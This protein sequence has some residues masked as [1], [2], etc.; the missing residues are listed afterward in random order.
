MTP[1]VRISPAALGVILV[2]LVIQVYLFETV[3]GAVLDGQRK[4]LPGAFG[5]SL[6]LTAICLF[7]AFRSTVE[8]GPKD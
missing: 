7:L 5:V 8:H 2:L 4:V 1:R 6:A 3:L